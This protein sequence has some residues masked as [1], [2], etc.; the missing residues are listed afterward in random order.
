MEFRGILFVVTSCFISVQIT[1][2]GFN[3]LALL[4]TWIYLSSTSGSKL[5]SLVKS[6]ELRKTQRVC[7]MVEYVPSGTRC[8]RA[9]DLKWCAAVDLPA[10]VMLA[11]ATAIASNLLCSLGDR[12]GAYTTSLHRLFVL[13]YLKVLRIIFSRLLF[14]YSVSWDLPYMTVFYYQSLVHVAPWAYILIL[15]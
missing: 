13:C 10:L 4:G 2:F 15:V 5:T 14:C 8:P 7:L 6:W 11:I 12:C 1:A 3:G 9:T